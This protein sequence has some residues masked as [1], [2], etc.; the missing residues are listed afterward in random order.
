MM[1]CRKFKKAKATRFSGVRE[2][3]NMKLI[4]KAVLCLAG[5]TSVTT[6]YSLFHLML[7]TF[8]L[9]GWNTEMDISKDR[10]SF[11]NYFKSSTSQLT[12]TLLLLIALALIVVQFSPDVSIVITDTGI[13]TSSS[14]LLLHYH[15]HHSP[16]AIH[17]YHHY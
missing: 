9:E 4:L 5:T 15:R 2:R 16:D 12:H 7:M 8:C 11:L 1:S 10:K 17:H 13:A 14:L 3:M 6:T